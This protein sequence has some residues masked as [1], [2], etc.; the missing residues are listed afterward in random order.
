MDIQLE[1][2]PC[3]VK[4]TLSVLKMVNAKDSTRENIMRDVLAKLSTGD[5]AAS[6]FS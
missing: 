1:C 5:G 3:F 4:Q 2:L 6:L